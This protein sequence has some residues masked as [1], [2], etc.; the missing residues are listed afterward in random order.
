MPELKKPYLGS[1]E[2]Y[3]KQVVYLQGLCKF[4]K[5]IF[6]IILRTQDFVTSGSDLLF[7]CQ[8]KI[9]GIGPKNRENFIV[10]G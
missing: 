7:Q 8:R 1:N 2:S 10:I 9:T 5:P 6:R 4:L 3:E